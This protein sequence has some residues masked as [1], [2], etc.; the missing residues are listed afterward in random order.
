MIGDARHRDAGAPGDDA[1]GA[2]AAPARNPA[3]V[4]LAPA[5]ATLGNLACGMLAALCCLAASHPLAGPSYV[6]VGCWLVAL[7]I[8]LDGLDGRLARRTARPTRFGAR[9]DSLADVVSFGV[10]PALLLVTATLDTHAP[11]ALRLALGTVAVA[12]VA[13]AALRLA[14]QHAHRGDRPRPHFVGLP[15]PGAAAALVSA[16]L[17]REQGLTPS[18]ALTDWVMVGWAAALAG[19]AVS[20]APYPHLLR[21]RMRACGRWELLAAAPCVA[22]LA[23]IDPALALLALAWAYVAWPVWTALRRDY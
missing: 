7:A 4:E 23:W 21:R 14:R 5:L 17:V 12:Y 10:A 3:P 15:T 9:L 16:I 18:T 20:H 6:A 8:V 13:C 1:R 22:V 19:L 2:P 11:H